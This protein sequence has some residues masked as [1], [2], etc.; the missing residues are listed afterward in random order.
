VV[1]SD[2]DQRCGPGGGARRGP[3]IERNL[4]IRNQTWLWA[5]RKGE[6]GQRDCETNAP[7]RL[8]ARRDQTVQVLGNALHQRETEAGARLAGDHGGGAADKRIKQPREFLRLD[9]GSIVGDSKG[10]RLP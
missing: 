9:A 5:G 10:E 4:R 7:A 8:A 3:G 6:A 2:E 1:F